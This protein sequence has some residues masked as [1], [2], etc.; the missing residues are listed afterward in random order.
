MY[1]NV[2]DTL[3]MSFFCLYFSVNTFPKILRKKGNFSWKNSLKI[4]RANGILILIWSRWKKS[5]IFINSIFYALWE[6]RKS[7]YCFGFFLD[8]WISFYEKSEVWGFLLGLGAVAEL[9]LGIRDR[10]NSIRNSF[11]NLMKA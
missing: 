2:Y 4:V 9:L 11:L 7:F 6:W 1:S 5:F 3:I 10:N 8:K